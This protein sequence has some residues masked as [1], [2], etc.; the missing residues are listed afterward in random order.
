[1]K[2]ILQH[3]NLVFIFRIILGITFIYASIDKIADPLTFS[4][5]IDNYHITPVFLNNLFAIIIAI[6]ELILGLCLITGILIDGALS[7]IIFLL[8]WF[9]FIISQALVRGIDLHCGCFDLASKSIND[10][11]L[12]LEMF[13]RIIEDFV[14]LF[15]AFFIK[16]R[17]KS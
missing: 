10:V 6:L 5:S 16:Y 7:I 11:N 14:F 12:R 13:K 1:M 3:S 4:N 2:K 15:M 8:I 17:K 9:V